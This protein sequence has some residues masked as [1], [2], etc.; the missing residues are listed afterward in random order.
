MFRNCLK[1]SREHSERLSKQKWIG[2]ILKIVFKIF[3]EYLFLWN[4]IQNI[5]LSIKYLSI[6]FKKGCY[7]TYKQSKIAYSTSHVFSK[8]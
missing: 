3:N 1:F 4:T 8:K 2:I 7:L 6:V 5:S